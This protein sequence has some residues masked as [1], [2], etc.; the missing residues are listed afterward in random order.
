MGRADRSVR[1]FWRLGRSENRGEGRRRV[2]CRRL[3]R[4]VE[5]LG[6]V[7][8]VFD[9]MCE[10]SLYIAGVKGGALANRVCWAA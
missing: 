1:R 6:V 8:E 5:C 3:R 10:P 4:S 7:S 9:G 2:W